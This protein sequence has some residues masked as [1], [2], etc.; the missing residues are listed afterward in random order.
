MFSSWSVSVSKISFF[1]LSE[2]LLQTLI[3]R[4]CLLCLLYFNLQVIY[5]ALSPWH[6]VDPYGPAAQDQLMITN[7]RVRLLQRQPCPCQA[8]L[9]DAAVLPTDHYAIYDFIVKGSCLCN[10]HADHCAPAKGYQPSQQKPS[11]MVSHF[12]LDFVNI[13]LAGTRYPNKEKLLHS[14][15][16]CE[17]LLRCCVMPKSHSFCFHFYLFYVVRLSRVWGFVPT[18]PLLLSCALV[19]AAE[20]EGCTED[21]ILGHS[22]TYHYRDLR[23]WKP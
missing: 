22:F 23:M 12:D 2:R 6:S 5:R 10:G 21:W 8:K 18:T 1:R 7:L 9:P 15:F 4:D 14:L 11:N 16:C 20:A 17:N 3:L 19:C 13:Q